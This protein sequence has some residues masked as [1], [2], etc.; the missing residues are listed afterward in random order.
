MTRYICL[1]V[2]RGGGGS[3]VFLVSG[4]FLF[5][6]L[7]AYFAIRTVR[8]VRRAQLK[9]RVFPSFTNPKPT[10]PPTKIMFGLERILGLNLR[11]F[12]LRRNWRFYH[13]E[14]RARPLRVVYP[15]STDRSTP[16]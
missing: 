6:V 15:W 5:C 2:L 14:C 3:S 7:C 12:F 8:T 16:V 1:L 11:F 4:L 10:E 13:V 9:Y